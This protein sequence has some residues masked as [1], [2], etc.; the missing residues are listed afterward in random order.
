M[1]DYLDWTDWTETLSFLSEAVNRS[2][3]THGNEIDRTFPVF[4][5]DRFHELQLFLI[6]KSYRV[7]RRIFLTT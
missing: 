7:E 5:I 2:L 1:S 6:V 4:K 3:R